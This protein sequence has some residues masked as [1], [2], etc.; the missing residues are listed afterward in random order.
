MYD[1]DRKTGSEYEYNMSLDRYMQEAYKVK[2]CKIIIAPE[3]KFYGEMGIFYIE[4]SNQDFLKTLKSITDERVMVHFLSQN[5]QYYKESLES[6]KEWD[7]IIDLH[8]SMKRLIKDDTIPYRDKLC[9]R[10]DLSLIP[11]VGELYKDK[12]FKIEEKELEE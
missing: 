8:E 12:A 10:V 3:D 11:K 5:E 9:D 2:K 1:N 7:I 6:F 4:S